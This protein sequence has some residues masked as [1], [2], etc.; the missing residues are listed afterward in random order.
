MFNVHAYFCLK[1]FEFRLL[2]LLTTLYLCDK[3]AMCFNYSV[4]QIF[5]TWDKLTIIVFYFRQMAFKLNMYLF[6]VVVMVGALHAQG[7]D[8]PNTM[9]KR[10]RRY[11]STC[12]LPVNSYVTLFGKTYVNALKKTL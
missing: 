8:E 10:F 9:G 12:C 5:T 2:N 11:G 6:L 3:F 7:D 1:L 4:H